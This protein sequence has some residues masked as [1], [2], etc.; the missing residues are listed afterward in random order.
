MIIWQTPLPAWLTTWFKD[1]PLYIKKVEQ[2]WQSNNT[3]ADNF[4]DAVLE[5]LCGKK[6]EKQ[7]K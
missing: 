7:Y 2:K 5:I 3:A 4:S 6:Q 1:D